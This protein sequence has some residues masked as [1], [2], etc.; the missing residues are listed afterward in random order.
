MISSVSVFCASS[1]KVD[2]VYF[3]DAHEL[4]EILAKNHIHVLYGGGAIGLMGCLADT[5]LKNGG[6]ITGIIP[7]F[8]LEQG[9]GHAK[10]DHIIVENMHERKKKLAE[11]A[12]AIIA[13]PGGVGTMEELLEM[14]TLKQLGKLLVPIVI[15]NTNGFFNPL[16][17]LFEQMIEQHFMR[18]IHRNLWIAADKPSDVLNAI[19]NAPEWDGSAIKYA[20]A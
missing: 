12:D 7:Q 18:D 8:M 4:G 13:L 20:P 1:Q 17:S 10:V 9:W 14:L 6:K 19:R 15:L 16:L 11:N 5:I 2:P 3:Q